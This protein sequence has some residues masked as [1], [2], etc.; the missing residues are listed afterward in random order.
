MPLARYALYTQN[1]DI[2]VAPTWDCGDTWQATMQ[3]VAR[4]GGYWV[5]DCATALEASDIPTDIPYFDKLFPN[6]DEWINPGDVVIYKPFGGICAGPMRR[7][8]GFLTAEINVEEARASRRKFD[9]SGHYAC[10]DVFSLSVDRQMK[11]PVAFFD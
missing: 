11:P 10:P 4:E 2:Y 8:K 9:A 1:I 7:E 3:H 5:I 6:K